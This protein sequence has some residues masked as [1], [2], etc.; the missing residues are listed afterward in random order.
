MR[1]LKFYAS[2][3]FLLTFF[4][5]LA[6]DSIPPSP[7]VDSSY[8]ETVRVDTIVIRSYQGKIRSIRRGAHL[9][10]PRIN[11]RGTTPLTDPYAP[12]RVPSFWAKENLLSIGL[13]EVA[14]VN[15]NA[16]GD[17]SVTALGRLKFARN[18]KFRYISWQNDLELRFGWNAQEGRKW[19]KTEDA[20]RLNSTFSYRRDT[21]SNWYY[22]VKANFRTQMA[23]GFKYPDRTKPISRF[24]A[25]GYLFFGAGASYIAQDNNFN[26]YISPITHRTTFVLDETLANQGA[27]GVEKAKLDAMGNVITPGKRTLTEFGFLVT[28]NWTTPIVDKVVMDHRLNLY[29]DY[30]EDIGNVDV[31]WEL[32]F[33]MVINEYIKATIGGHMIYDDDIRFDVQKDEDGN[34]TDPGTPRIQLKQLLTIGVSYNF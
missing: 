20:V 31:E 16:G 4:P 26:L 24:M 28:N 32:N 27:F 1:R 8:A 33:N 17:N 12:F 19:R 5:I 23:D 15:W 29:M 25:P 22:S 6:Q 2:L 3:I 30:L 13:S 11:F 14:F 34:I 21:I 7:E 18:Y 9:I 10:P